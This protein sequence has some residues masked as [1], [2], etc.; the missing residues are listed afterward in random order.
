MPSTAPRNR[1]VIVSPALA[2]A[3][4]GNWQTARRWQQMLAPQHAARIVR[5]W[6]DALASDA[7]RVMLALHA[8]R[9][10]ASAA[11]WAR[12]RGAADSARGLAVVLTGTDLYRDIHASTEAL[13]S[14]HL[15]QQLVVLQECGPA[16]LPD[17]LRRK[18]RVMFQSTSARQALPKSQA[19]LRA[20]MVGHLR[21]EKSPETLFAAARLL[22]DDSALFIDHIGDALDP[23]LGDEA[24]ATAAACPRYRWLGG[25]AREA[26]R[27]RIQRAHVLVHASRMEGG[28]HVVME[29][30]RSGTPVLASRIDGNVGML[31]HDYAGYFDWGDAAGLA[32]LLRRCGESQSNPTGQAGRPGNLLA[33][34]GAQCA[35]RAGLFSADTERAALRQLVAELLQPA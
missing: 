27:R 26:T 17:A 29:A 28:A 1:V 7:D 33:H 13:Q 11:A 6:P 15:A 9:S 24:R 20:V 23:A 22:K 18:T 12:A 2:D 4:N 16:S 5:Q 25:L 14:L 8:R 35:L 19:Q 21:E 34:L 31:G 10:A 32:A 3:N 30:I